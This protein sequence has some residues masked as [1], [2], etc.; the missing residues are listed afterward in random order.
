M[1]LKKTVQHWEILKELFI[2]R[3]IDFKEVTSE[4]GNILTKIICLIYL[5]DYASIYLSVKLETDPTPVEAI[6]FIKKKIKG[7]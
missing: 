6:D 1:I 7:I 4:N 5:F 3:E 2:E